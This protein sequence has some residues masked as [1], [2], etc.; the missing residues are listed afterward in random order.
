MKNLFNR[1]ALNI[2]TLVSLID[3][4]VKKDI[5]NY[6][7]VAAKKGASIAE[8][9]LLTLIEL[10]GLDPN[11]AP[12]VKVVEKAPEVREIPSKWLRKV[13]YLKDIENKLG[14]AVRR[15]YEPIS[16]L[17]QITNHEKLHVDYA[18]FHRRSRPYEPEAKNEPVEIQV[19][20]PLFVV[21]DPISNLRDA[22]K[23]VGNSPPAPTASM[24]EALETLIKYA[25]LLQDKSKL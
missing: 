24:K 14:V 3:D 4:T 15:T 10:K 18:G 12:Q 19:I 23:G 2:K 7:L 9:V 20:Q 17:L 6:S 16:D 5:V 8:K 22:I 11:P 13:T 21:K 25:S 1:K